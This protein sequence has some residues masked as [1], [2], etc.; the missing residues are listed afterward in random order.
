[1]FQTIQNKTM[2]EALLAWNEKNKK[3]K[4]VQNVKKEVRILM[5][6]RLALINRENKMKEDINNGKF[7][8]PS[9]YRLPLSVISQ[10]SNKSGASNSASLSDD[11]IRSLKQTA[12]IKQKLQAVAICYGVTSTKD[13]AEDETKFMFDPYIAGKPY[14][15]YFIQIRFS[16]QSPLLRGHSLPHAVPVKSLYNKHF[17]QGPSGGRN[18]DKNLRNFLA[19]IF[20]HLRA[21]LSRQQQFNDMKKSFSTDL[22]ECN[23]RNHFTAISFSLSANNEEDEENVTMVL[24]MSY[25]I[26]MERPR[27][28]S[29]KVDFRP[30]ID[31][32]TMD[33]VVVDCRK[34]YEMNLVD[35]LKSVFV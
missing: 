25:D 24:S 4:E 18:Q 13:E 19:D 20:R 30:Q 35:A 27:D 14:G 1:M 9:S 17:P 28:H 5:R 10:S 31:K 16:S 22:I 21:F 2:D 26:D 23:A 7:G 34:F 11:D 6:K 15:P 3:E 33:Q 32:E 8:P 29:L 12:K